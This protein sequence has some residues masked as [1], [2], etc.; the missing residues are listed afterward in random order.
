[1]QPPAMQCARNT[2]FVERRTLLKLSG[3]ALLATTLPIAERAIP[4]TAASVRPRYPIQIC[5]GYELDGTPIDPD[6]IYSM[7][8]TAPFGV[9]AMAVCQ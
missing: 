1:M 2:L 3:A 9:G 5:G 8:F 6:D 7:A 4:V